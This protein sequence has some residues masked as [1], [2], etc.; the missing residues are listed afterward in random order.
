MMT[1]LPRR[2]LTSNSIGARTTQLALVLIIGVPSLAQAKTDSDYE[3]L[4]DQCVDRVIK[5]NHLAGINNG[6]VDACTNHVSELT[7]KEMNR[8]YKT[9]Y[10]RLNQ[11]SPEDAK[12]FENSQKSWL[13]Y[14][15]S[16]CQLMGRYVGSPMY[17]FCP[18]QLNIARV[19]ELKELVGE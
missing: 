6:V 17:G 11:E 16:H 8:L 9:F 12:Q 15:N 19:S 10:D 18:M 7:K 14:R 2:W 5:E 4:Y 1:H 3:K 13:T